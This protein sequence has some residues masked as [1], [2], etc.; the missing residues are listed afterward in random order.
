[1]ANRAARFIDGYS[2]GL[3]GPEA[4]WVNQKYHGHFLPPAVVKELK[5]EF[6]LKYGLNTE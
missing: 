3:T 1:Y 5:K 6:L 4:T 2:Q